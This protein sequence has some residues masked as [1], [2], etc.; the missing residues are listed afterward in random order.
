M[1]VCLTMSSAGETYSK[2]GIHMDSEL[3]Y[4]TGKLNLL[5][6]QRPRAN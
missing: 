4:A 1:G 3:P 2:S 6:R 5:Q